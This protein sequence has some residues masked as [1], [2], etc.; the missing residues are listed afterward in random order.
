M[1]SNLIRYIHDEEQPDAL[2]Q[3]AVMHYQFEAIHPFADGNGRVGRIMI[4]LYLFERK[5]TE[6]PNLYVSEFLET[7]RRDYYEKLNGISEKNEWMEWIEFFLRAVR[8]QA[9]LSKERVEKVEK[10]YKSLYE[11]LP[12]FNSIYAPAFLEA[13]F[14][15]PKFTPLLIGKAANIQNSQTTYNLVAKFAEVGLITDLTPRKERGKLYSFEP[16]LS[17]L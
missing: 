1:I 10:L 16:L 3:A 5:I 4:P 14:S 11:R 12:E 13:L 9:N 17:I 8:E 7:H 6:Y 15:N 2:I